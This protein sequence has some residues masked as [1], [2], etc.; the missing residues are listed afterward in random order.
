MSLCYVASLNRFRGVMS[1]LKILFLTP[2]MNFLMHI[3]IFYFW[4]LSPGEDDES[5]G[6][7]GGAIAGIVIGCVV[8]CCCCC[9]ISGIGIII[10]CDKTGYEDCD[11][12]CC[13]SCC[14]SSRRRHSFNYDPG[15]TDRA[16]IRLETISEP[17][18]NDDDNKEEV[19]VL[20]DIIVYDL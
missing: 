13:T 9:I 18:N 1:I 19:S 4:P 5:G 10:C 14:R 16:E 12:S 11:Y 20:N 15:H 7:S 6:L 8:F 17:N 3:L 2:K